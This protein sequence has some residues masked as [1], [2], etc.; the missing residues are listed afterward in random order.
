MKTSS[1][2]VALVALFLSVFVEISTAAERSTGDAEVVVWGMSHHL[3]APPEGRTFNETNP[4]IGFRKYFASRNNIEVFADAH[5]VSKNST[6]GEAVMVGIGGQYP[7]AS[8]GRVDVLVGGVAG[9]SRYEN[10]WERKVYVAPGAYPFLGL[11]WKYITL[12]VGYVP[13]VSVDG[14]ATYSTLFAY[15]SM[16]F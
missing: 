8:M 5:Y 3:S 12:T 13:N 16:R 7:F 15:A 11:R 10:T 6:S 14:M 1:V 4:G 9:I 2:V